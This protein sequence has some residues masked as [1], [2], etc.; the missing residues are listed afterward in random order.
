MNLLGRL[1]DL[2][3]KKTRVGPKA[4]ALLAASVADTTA[5]GLEKSLAEQGVVASEERW[6]N[7]FAELQVAFHC[8]AVFHV[9]RTLSP[10]RLRNF[11]TLMLADLAESE[12]D[13][14]PPYVPM[15]FTSGAT[16]EA[17][18]DTYVRGRP[19]AT[20]R[21]DYHDRRAMLRLPAEGYALPGLLAV[22]LARILDID[23]KGM[24]FLYLWLGVSSALIAAQKQ[25]FN[26]TLVPTL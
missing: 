20:T 13:G 2:F 26:A 18:L 19:D 22:R 7:A 6:L 15:V 14:M 8:L 17:G 4:M 1:K 16:V 12:K 9:R 24:Q 23:L 11:G 5:R 21:A 25:V 10:D 3:G